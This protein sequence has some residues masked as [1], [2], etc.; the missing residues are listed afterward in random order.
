MGRTEFYLLSSRAPS[1]SFSST[2]PN[3]GR[4]DEQQHTHYHDNDQPQNEQRN[5][6]ITANT[7]TANT[8]SAD[9]ENIGGGEGRNDKRT[10]RN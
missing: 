2:T 3:D 10:E 4:Q 1:C 6:T 7:A 5:N 9:A 8:A